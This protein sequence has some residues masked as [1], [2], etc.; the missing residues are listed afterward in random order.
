MSTAR[1]TLALLVCGYSLHALPVSA[2]EPAPQL[3]RLF[4]TPEWRANLERQRQFNIQET[5]SLEGGTMRL[6]GV[7][8]RSSGKSTAWVNNRPQAENSLD[9]GVAVATSRRQPGRATLTTGD[10]PPADL[11]VGVT[12]NRSTR[13]TAGGLADGE[14]RVNRPAPRK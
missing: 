3:G 5:R 8:V 9:S 1:F 13:E 2:A 11:P 12:L 4:M 7:V 10:E 6:D 14:I